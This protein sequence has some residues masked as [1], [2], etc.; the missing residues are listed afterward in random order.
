M[1]TIKK[2]S[3]N[4]REEVLSSEKMH[5]VLG[6]LDPITHAPDGTFVT[7][8][9]TFEPIKP[10]GGGNGLIAPGKPGIYTKCES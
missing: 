9:K 1:V 10:G 7:K 6:G 3:L 2:L 4:K 8:P 5:Q